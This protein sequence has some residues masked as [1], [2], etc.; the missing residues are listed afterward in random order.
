VPFLVAVAGD[1]GRH[2]VEVER[3][4]YLPVGEA[5]ALLRLLDG[6]YVDAVLWRAQQ[7]AAGNFPQTPASGDGLLV[8]PRLLRQLERT[9]AKSGYVNPLIEARDL[10]VETTD[11]G[12]DLLCGA[13]VADPSYR[14]QRDYCHPA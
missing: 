4:E 12:K 8:D 10:V 6:W 2:E 5:G 9:D 3:F 11:Q 13:A 1:T 7:F 14:C